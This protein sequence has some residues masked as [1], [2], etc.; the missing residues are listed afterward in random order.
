MKKR[1]LFVHETF[2]RMAGAE[3]NIQVTAPHLKQTFDLAFMYWNRSGKAESDFEAIFP[4]S[5]QVPFDGPPAETSRRVRAVLDKVSPDLVYVHKCIANPVLETLVAWGG[6]LVR[7]EH[8]HDIYC[9][10]SYKYSPWNR[11]ICT[12]KAGPCCLFPCLAFLKRDRARRPL[13]ISWVS[14]RRQMRCIA[15]NRRFSAMFVVTAYMRDELIRQGF[16][17]E[18]IHIFP[19]I[20]APAG[21][22]F[23]SSFSEANRIIF[24]GQIIR[25]KGLDALLRSLTL[26]RQPFRLTVLGSGSHQAYCE[27]LAAELGLSDRVEFPGFVPFEQLASYY[28]EA[29]LVAVPSLWPEPIATIGLEVLRYGLPV[30]GFDA[31]GIRDWLRDGET[32]FLIPWMDLPAMAEKIDHL[33][34]NKS[35]ARRLGEQGRL[36]VNREYAFE[37]YIERMRQTFAGMIGAR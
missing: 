1:I 29:T 35:E 24:A 14:Y 36:F 3:Q 12:R 32:G 19:P 8:D 10:R 5:F 37:P 2:G 33:L 11:R 34:A 7:M 9:M 22:T 17:P 15:L 25:G 16:A 21:Q 31:G 20:P 26:C 30:V 23:S 27:R 28:R 6:P 18:R 13:G 4:D